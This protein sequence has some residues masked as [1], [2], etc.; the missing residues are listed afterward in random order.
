MKARNQSGLFFVTIIDLRQKRMLKRIVLVVAVALGIIV[1]EFAYEFHTK[2]G[3]LN[4]DGGQPPT[5]CTVETAQQDCQ[6]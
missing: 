2:S 5:G 4:S 3:P 6:N 1:A